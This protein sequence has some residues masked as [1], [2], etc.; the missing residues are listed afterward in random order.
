VDGEKHSDGRFIVL[1]EYERRVALGDWGEATAQTLLKLAGFSG[2]RD[3]N[4]E[5]TTIHLATYTQSAR[6]SAI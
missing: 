5:S 3:V 2:V 4:I 6:K 1:T